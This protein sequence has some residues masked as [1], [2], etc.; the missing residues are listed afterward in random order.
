MEISFPRT[1]GT[2]RTENL[3][4]ATLN[5]MPN[6]TPPPAGH[7]DVM[8]LPVRCA[9]R[10]RDHVRGILAKPLIVGTRRTNHTDG[11]GTETP[12]GTPHSWEGHKRR[13]RTEKMLEGKENAEATQQLCMA[14]TLDETPGRGSPPARERTRQ[15][16]LRPA[17][18]VCT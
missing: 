12:V 15:R 14:L 18:H 8:C 1:N 16:Q 17:R 7:T 10:T 4:D 13:R 11:R 3:T 5:G 6:C 9:E 2:L